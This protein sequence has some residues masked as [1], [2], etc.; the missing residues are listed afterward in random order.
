MTFSFYT[1]HDGV[2]S[3]PREGERGPSCGH[4]YVVCVIDAPA[5]QRGGAM[6]IAF[7]NVPPVPSR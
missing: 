1:D 4:P 5:R 2:V 6:F 7:H 3:K